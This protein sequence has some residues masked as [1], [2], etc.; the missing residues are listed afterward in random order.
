VRRPRPWRA[1]ASY[2]LAPGLPPV[3]AGRCYRATEEGLQRFIDEATAAGCE[4]RVWQV[5][6][7]PEVEEALAATPPSPPVPSAP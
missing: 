3:V 6:P 4:V 5:Q 1:V 7:I 2:R